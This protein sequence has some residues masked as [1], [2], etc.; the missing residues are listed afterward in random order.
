MNIIQVFERFPTQESCIA[1]LE[2]ARW[3]DGPICPY[4]GSTNTAPNQHRHRCYNC[5]T[6]FSVTVGTIFHHT[7]LPLQK[8]FLAITLMLNAKKGLSA[9]QLSRDLEVNKN[10]AW[11]I[12]MQIRK[13]MT[14]AEHRDLL[15]GIVE[16][17]ETY[18][19]GKPRK[20]TKGDGPDGSHPRGRG[21]KKAP[22]VGAVERGGKVTA[23]TVKKDKMKGRHM[24]A[25]VRD[26]VDTSKAALVTDEYSLP[27]HGE[28]SASRRHQASGLVRRRRHSHEHH[29]GV[30]GA[31]EARH[32]RSV[33]TAS[34]GATCN[35]TWT[36]SATATTCGTPIRSTPHHDELSAMSEPLKVIAGTQDHPLVIGG[37]EIEC[38]VLENEI[39][40]LSRG[41]FQAALGRHRTSRKHQPDDVVNLPAFLAASNLKPF[42]SKDLVTA[43][44][45]LELLSGTDNLWLQRNPAPQ[46]CEVYLKQRMR[47]RLS[48]LRSILP[49]K[50]EF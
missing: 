34:A 7:H 25:F 40:V 43:S 50:R 21:T 6:G 45:R 37:V 13:A 44:Y 15:T 23:K 33:R 17:D 3:P 2:A 28:G 9:L 36:S 32:V 10:T 41:G 39:R 20:G 19:G 22:V 18:I 38:Y 31:A 42:I 11:R 12:T 26:R 46:V 29:R 48:P 5:K 8:W 4:C 1:H 27:R 16:M 24:R 30:L 14:Q 49:R 35:A 47:E